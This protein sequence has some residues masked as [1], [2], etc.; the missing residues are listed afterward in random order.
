MGGLKN[1]MWMELLAGFS[2][3]KKKKEKKKTAQF[4]GKF[5]VKF[6]LEQGRDTLHLTHGLILA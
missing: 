6:Q 4:S 1:H 2:S 5:F 3:Q